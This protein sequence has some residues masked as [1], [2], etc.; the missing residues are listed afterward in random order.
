MSP[1]SAGAKPPQ[2]YRQNKQQL[3]THPQPSQARDLHADDSRPAILD[4]AHAYS[5]YETQPWQ[6]GQQ[7]R[8]PHPAA[9]TKQLSHT[10]L[11]RLDSKAEN[12]TAIRVTIHPDHDDPK[13][14]FPSKAPCSPN[15]SPKKS[16]QTAKLQDIPL[17]IRLCRLTQ[18]RL[19]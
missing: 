13:P 15:S 12:F 17:S 8:H 14:S 11:L 6:P 7:R 1:Q 9:A 18:L 10:S 19:P 3:R 2:L 4:T 5:E 16:R